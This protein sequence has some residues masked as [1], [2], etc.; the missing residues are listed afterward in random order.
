[1][2]GTP[3]IRTLDKV[4]ASKRKRNV[5]VKENL[6]VFSGAMVTRDMLLATYA[7]LVGKKAP[8][9]IK[10]STLFA[11][12]GKALEAEEI[13]A[14]KAG[15]ADEAPAQKPKNKAQFVAAIADKFKSAGIEKTEDELKA[16][17]DDNTKAEL[18]TF[19][20]DEENFKA[21]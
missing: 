11:E 20:A 9:N 10:T 19:L 3:D 6:N 7:T 21:E 13:E 15:K 16:L 5:K 18:E 2:P 4:I 12:I 14:A 1:M 8:E 17:E